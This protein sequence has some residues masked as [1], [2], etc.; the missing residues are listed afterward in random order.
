MRAD[1]LLLD[2]RH[3]L[4]RSCDAFK[5]LS[6]TTAEGK[7]LP[8]GGIYGFLSILLRIHIKYGGTAVIA[9]EGRGNF[10]RDLY[11]EYKRKAEPSPEQLSIIYEMLD[12]ER[13][14]KALLRLLGVRQYE[15]DGFEADDVLGTLAHRSAVKGRAVSIYSGDSDLRQMVNAQIQVIAPGFKGQEVIYNHPEAV[16]LKHGVY[17]ELIPDLKA[18]SGDNSDNIPGLKGIGQVTA[19]KVINEHGTVEGVIKAAKD[20]VDLGVAERFRKVIIDGAQTLRL[21]KKLT[22]ISREATIRAI[23]P[24]RDAERARAHF[25]A[26]KFKSLCEPAEW[27]GMMRLGKAS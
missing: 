25:Y 1:L 17:P 19:A 26:Y 5:D 3:L 20:G 16:K 7:E 10:R 15:G 6:I 11:P 9:W 24:M 4:W 13:R 14:L 8:T 12:Q 2:G 22:T 18:L 21:Y 23:D 27:M